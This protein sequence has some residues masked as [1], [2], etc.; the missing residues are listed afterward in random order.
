MKVIRAT[1]VVSFICGFWIKKNKLTTICY[2]NRRI[3]KITLF[4]SSGMNPGIE[5]RRLRVYHSGTNLSTYVT[6]RVS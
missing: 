4:E 1:S 3:W 2:P 6:E 5:P